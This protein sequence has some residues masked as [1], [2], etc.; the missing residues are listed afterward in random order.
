[1]LGAARLRH[2]S[3]Q[4][5]RWCSAAGACLTVGVD[6]LVDGDGLVLCGQRGLLLG[7]R[8]GLRLG[9]GKLGVAL[10]AL[11]RLAGRS[12][13]LL[14]RC[15]ALGCALRDVLLALLCLLLEPL[16]ALLGRLLDLLATA[17]SS[18]A[19]RVEL[20]VGLEPLLLGNRLEL[21]C[22]LQLGDAGLTEPAAGDELL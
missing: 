1:M 14:R 11:D 2:R 13:L 8:L 22:F 18:F 4:S 16:L 15:L 12:G 19:A 5:C 20:V 6:C 21:R 3:S 17:L 10:L 7:E 9:G